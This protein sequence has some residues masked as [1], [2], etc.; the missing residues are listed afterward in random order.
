MSDHFSD[1][2]SYWRKYFPKSF[3]Y[4]LYYNRPTANCNNEKTQ[5]NYKSFGVLMSSVA[6]S[7]LPKISCMLALEAVRHGVDWSGHVHFTF[8]RGRS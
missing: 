2:K 3:G 8:A 7:R 1:G 4:N 6:V 5:E